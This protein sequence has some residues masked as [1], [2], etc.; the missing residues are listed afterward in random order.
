MHKNR[1]LNDQRNTDKSTVTQDND[2]VPL[3]APISDGITY[4]LCAGIVD[5]NT[6]LH[7]I[8]QQEVLEEC[9]YDVPEEKFE[10]VFSSRSS[11]GV[12]GSVQSFFYAEVTDSMIVSEGGGNISEGES[13][14]VYYLPTAKVKQFLFDES[15]PKPPSLMAAFFW[16][17]STKSQEKL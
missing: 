16:Y 17:Q 2:A 4:E 9:G 12:A 1:T 3:K 7:S 14:E 11:V 8:I 6:A 5:K 10:R 13:I 15:L